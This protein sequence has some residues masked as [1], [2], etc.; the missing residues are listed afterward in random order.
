MIGQ[1]T[2]KLMAKV[3]TGLTF[4]LACGSMAAA[5]PIT[6]REAKKQLFSPKRSE[7]EMIAHDF[8]SP[9]NSALLEQVAQGY[10]YYAAVAVA[11][12]D[13]LL[14]SEA[15]MLVANHHSAEAASVA[16]LAGC[17]AARKSKTPCEVVALVKPRKWEAR[18]VQ[19]SLE[20]TLALDSDYGRKGPR[21]LAIS[22]TTGFFGLGQGDGAGQTATAVCSEKGAD[23]CIVVVADE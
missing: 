16:A 12:D 3:I 14:K 20:A 23:D 13:E 22:P 7:V 1:T 8:L 18:D 15:T 4:A 19:L 17:D 2:G 9:E 10:A 6:I 11:P 5:E 21:A